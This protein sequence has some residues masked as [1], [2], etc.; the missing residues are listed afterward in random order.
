LARIVTAPI[1]AERATKAAQSF[2]PH[3]DLADARWDFAEARVRWSLA[4]LAAHEA[5]ERWRA[6]AR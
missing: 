3:R 4:G 5:A 1:G 2:Y 6:P